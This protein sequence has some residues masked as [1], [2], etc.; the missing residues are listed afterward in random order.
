MI[1]IETVRQKVGRDVLVENQVTASSK[2]WRHNANERL[3]GFGPIF[4]TP[5]KPDYQRSD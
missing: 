4:A 5:T 1:Q 3:H 2:R